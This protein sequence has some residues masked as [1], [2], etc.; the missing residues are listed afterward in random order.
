MR[1]MTPQE[2]MHAIQ[3]RQH[4]LSEIGKVEIRAEA[5][6]FSSRE[7]WAREAESEEFMNAVKSELKYAIAQ[8]L[9]KDFQTEI[10]DAHRMCRFLARSMQ[11]SS[12]VEKWFAPLLERI[13]PKLTIAESVK[14]S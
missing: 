13:A 7:I 5:R 14:N 10:R 6:F 12:D 4:P 1:A 11:E 8:A 3:F 9:Y 2:I